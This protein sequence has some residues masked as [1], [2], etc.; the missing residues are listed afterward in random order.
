MPLL[1]LA[2]ANSFNGQHEPFKQPHRRGDQTFSPVGFFQL[3]LGLRLL[4]V[5]PSI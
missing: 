4:P 3:G 1:P 5:S 2:A